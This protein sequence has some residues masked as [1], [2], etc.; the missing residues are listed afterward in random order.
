MSLTSASGKWLW[1][2]RIKKSLLREAGYREQYSFSIIAG[3]DGLRGWSPDDTDWTTQQR[4]I[5]HILSKVHK[6]CS[7][8][9]SAGTF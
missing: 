4:G 6:R 3:G 7:I 8:N 5:H 9:E 1:G 2:K